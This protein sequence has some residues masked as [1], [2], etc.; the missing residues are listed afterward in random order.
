MKDYYIVYMIGDDNIVYLQFLNFMTERKVTSAFQFASKLEI[1]TSC[2]GTL[3]TV[4][5]K[6]V[7]F[8]VVSVKLKTFVFND[9][10]MTDYV[11]CVL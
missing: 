1:Q 8:R 9:K 11:I 4:L 2:I 7:P 5:V 6:K 10:F 3:F